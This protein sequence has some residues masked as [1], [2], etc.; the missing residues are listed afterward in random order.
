VDTGGTTAKPGRVG[1]VPLSARGLSKDL[2]AIFDHVKAQCEAEATD[3]NL[4]LLQ[5]PKYVAN[6]V[7]EAL[8]EHPE[9]DP[10]DLD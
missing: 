4:G 1:G 3:K 9:A 6:C 7:T 2:P 8:K 10:Y 5:R